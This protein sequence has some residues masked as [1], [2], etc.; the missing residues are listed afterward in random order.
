MIKKNWKL[1][2]ITSI[3]ILLPIAAG[4]ILWN[5][6]PDPMPSH[7]GING[8]VDG[9]SSKPVSV[10]GMPALLLAIQWA[11]VLATTAD[12]K[13]DNHSAKILQLAF[14]IAP[15]LSV[16]LNT[17]VYA[18]ALGHEVQFKLLLPVI[19]GVLFV[20]IG[21]YMPKCRRNYT[22]G[23]KI[24]WTLNSDENWNRTH[25]LAG[26]V[27]VAG[28]FGILLSGFAGGVWLMLGITIM[29]VAAP[30]VYSYALYRKGI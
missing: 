19:L 10:F 13:K 15:I 22:I 8:E 6:L 5:R 21:N 11:C 20:A 17:A 7:W 28:G 9:W 30:L 2:L 14:W 23:I 26:K 12:P 18:A 4:L 1:L 27:W 24:P 25:R 3:I 16:V 29:M